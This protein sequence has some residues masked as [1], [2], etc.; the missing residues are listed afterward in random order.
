MHIAGYKCF[1]GGAR[2]ASSREPNRLTS[3]TGLSALL[4]EKGSCPQDASSFGIVGFPCAGFP[5]G[6]D[7][8]G[9]RFNVFTASVATVTITPGNKPR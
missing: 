1:S 5:G 4:R 6:S 7:D 2:T 9:H 3:R 8:G